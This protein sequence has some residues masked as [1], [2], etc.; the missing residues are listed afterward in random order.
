M[1]KTGF[2]DS[3]PGNASSM[4]LAFIMIIIVALFLT[5]LMVVR[6]KDIVDVITLYTTMTATAITLKTIQNSQ[7]N[8]STKDAP[9]IS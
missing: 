3:S 5:I 8:N 4:R 6:N 7:E 9:P 1:E 2:L